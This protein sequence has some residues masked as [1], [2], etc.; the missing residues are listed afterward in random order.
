M[1][2]SLDLSTLRTI[3]SALQSEIKRCERI[4]DLMTARQMR[5]RNALAKVDAAI[6]SEHEKLAGV[7]E[8]E[9]HP[10]GPYDAMGRTVYCDGSCRR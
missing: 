3:K 1:T 2:D 5:I 7:K 4:G 9:G 8:C 10:A 6:E